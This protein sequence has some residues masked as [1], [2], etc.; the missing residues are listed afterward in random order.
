VRAHLPFEPG[1]ARLELAREI[2]DVLRAHRSSA[3]VE[4]SEGLAMARARHRQ[5]G[6][7]L[8]R[9]RAGGGEARGDGR[10]GGKGRSSS[11]STTRTRGNSCS[12]ADQRVDRT[13][14]TSSA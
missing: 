3:P 2:C 12:A 1:G 10:I 8:A 9:Q 13:T 6:G 11:S 5:R 7:D 4:G 14:D